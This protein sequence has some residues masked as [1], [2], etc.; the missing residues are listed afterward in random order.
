MITNIHIEKVCTL[1][2]PTKRKE[3]KF[4]LRD[5]MCYIESCYIRIW[6]IKSDLPLKLIRIVDNL[7]FPLNFFSD[8]TSEI[9]VKHFVALVVF[10]LQFTNIVT[11]INYYYLYR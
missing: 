4:N 7:I 11:S 1:E 9:S 6:Y 2:A 3:I 10:C 5:C 8:K